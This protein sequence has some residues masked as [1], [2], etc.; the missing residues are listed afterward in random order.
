MP[1]QRVSEI[2]GEPVVGKFY[3]V[4][5][6]IDGP[7][8][9]WRPVIGPLHDDVEHFGFKTTHY[10][11]DWRFLADVDCQII[12]N[13]FDRPVSRLGGLM[14]AIGPAV[15]TRLKR[16][17]CLRPMPV[18]E[19]AFSTDKAGKR[20]A[21]FEQH[22]SNQSLTSCLKCPH[23][24]IPLANLPKDEQGNVVCSGHGLK[25]NLETGKLVS[26]L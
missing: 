5:C 11:Y 22:F 18:F 14:A 23:R 15:E 9:D 3:L 21:K 1:I 17:K 7:L 6:I 2:E 13:C 10:H 8:R 26:R 12:A 4:Q 16:M 19:L 25:W 24:G 20:W